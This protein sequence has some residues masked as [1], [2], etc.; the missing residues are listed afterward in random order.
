VQSIEGILLQEEWKEF[1]KDM[2]YKPIVIFTLVNNTV[3]YKTMVDTGCLC[4]ALCDPTF[5]TRVNLEHIP[6]RL[7]YIEA[8]NGEE[9]AR[10]IQEVAV[11]EIDMEGFT[12]RIWYYMTPLGGYD[13][14]LGLSWLRKRNVTIDRGEERLRVDCSSTPSQEPTCVVVWSQKTFASETERI[15]S[16]RLVSAAG[17]LTASR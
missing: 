2:H 15:S 16:A 12:D 10:P 3:F 4:Y 1:K 8:F 9:T 14:Y 13:M 17:W 7:F 6:I 11:T 5:V